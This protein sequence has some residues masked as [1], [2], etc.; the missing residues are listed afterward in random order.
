MEKR[1]L[2]FQRLD[3]WKRLGSFVLYWEFAELRKELLVVLA[4]KMR[5]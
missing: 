1:D 5:S 2:N 4:T 3:W